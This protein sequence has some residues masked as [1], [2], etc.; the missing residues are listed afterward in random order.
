MTSTF[1]PVTVL[2]IFWDYS[3][4]DCLTG[5]CWEYAPNTYFVNINEE[6]M[7][8]AAFRRE[9]S[10]LAFA[11]TFPTEFWA[12]EEQGGTAYPYE[13]RFIRYLKYLEE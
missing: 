12:T 8:D 9:S 10:L 7:T 3:T 6:G 1:N 5:A 13:K 4:T 2:S 11:M